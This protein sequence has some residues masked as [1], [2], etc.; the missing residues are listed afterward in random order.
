MDHALPPW[1]DDPGYRSLLHAIPGSAALVNGRGIVE[2]VNPSWAKTAT[3]N[4]FI[5]GLGPGAD[6][7]EHCRG[8]LKAADSNHALVALG[9]VGA[10]QGK[11]R[12]IKL[13]Y[14]VTDDGQVRWFSMT[15]TSPEDEPP[16]GFRVVIAHLDITDRIAWETRVRRN[17]Q[18]F[19]TTTENALDL[20]AIVAADG[21]TIYASPSYGK[22]LGYGPLVMAKCKLLDLVC[23]PDKAAFRDN[24]RIGLSSGISPLFEY[25]VL[26]QDGQLRRM[27]ARAVAVDNP[28][29]ERESILLISRDVSSKKEAEDERAQMEVQLRHAQ[30]MEAIGQLSAGIAHEINTPC[31]YLSDNLKFLQEAF[32]GFLAVTASL[33]R[34]LDAQAAPPAEVEAL[35]RDL[36]EQD[37][38][39]LVEEVPRALQQSLDGLAR[40]ATIVKAMKVFGHPGGE[41]QVAVDLNESLR[42]TVVVA[43]SEWKYLAEVKT[44]L[45]PDLPPVLCSPGELNQ[46]LLNLVVNAAHAIG[47]KLGA[48]P[49]GKGVI[50]LA[51]RRQGPW[52]EI[53]VTDTGVGI[54]ENIRGNVF[55]P[56]FTTKPVGKGTGQGLS[57]A[58][59]VITKS[60]GTIDFESVDG[61]GTCFIIRLPV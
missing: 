44:D 7:L 38:D 13:E 43:Q 27:E 48:M 24:C 35:R 8:L 51:S 17:E 55:L 25:G 12:R 22:T 9:I 29:G 52:V 21:R 45:D 39:Y 57:I 54:P 3:S 37:I 4:P 15:G 6:Y 40:I 56:F 31:Q 47:E 5:A 20:I 18:L 59:S 2:A 34:V 46:V 33:G 41:E 36:L 23:D 10:L 61:Q 30:K 32:G 49:A 26:H 14:P 60:G 16:A 28:G 1:G 19:K 53:R 58:H 42:N 11:V 50:T